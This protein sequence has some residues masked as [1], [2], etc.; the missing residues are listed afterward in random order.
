V[1]RFVRYWLPLLAWVALIFLLSAQPELPQP[2]G[3]WLENVRDKVAHA[4]SY[5]VL[6]W[7]LWR[8]LRLFYPPT[9]SLGLICVTLVVSYGAS[10]ELHQAFVPGRTASFADL[11]ADAF[12]AVLATLVLVWAGRRRRLAESQASPQ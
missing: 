2:P 3:P 9:A 7:L 10:D 6:A 8:V 4:V 1:K 12:G 11:A 5:G